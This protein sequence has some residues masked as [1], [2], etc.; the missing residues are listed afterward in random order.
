MRYLP[1]FLDVRQRPV[2]LVGG[3]PVALRKF[4][5]L[6]SAGA[7]TTVVAPTLSAEFA[8][9]MAD[10][11]SRHIAALFAPEQLR[12]QHLVIA[13]TNHPAVNRSVAEAA[14]R[15]G[16]WAN[17][18]DDAENSSCIVPA[19]VDRSPLIVAISSGGSAP[20][21]A[22]WVRAKIEVLLD[23]SLGSLALLCARWRSRIATQIA[24]AQRRDFYTT[25][26]TGEVADLVRC[27]READADAAVERAL[28][29]ARAPGS[30]AGRVI[31][32]GA[33]PGDP[34]L[35]TLHALRALQSADVIL[36]DRLVSSDVLALA[37]RDAA[38]V[39][40]G[41]E[42][43]GVS[44]AQSTTEALMIEHARAGRVVVRLKGGDPFVFG[45]GGEELEALRRAGIAYEVVPGIS[46]AA[47]AAAYAGIPLTHRD[48]AAGLRFLTA[49]RRDGTPEP[50][51]ADWA[52]S[53]ETLAIYMGLGQLPTL[54]RELLRHGRDPQ[55][56]VALIENVSRPH[57]R[58]AVGAL[59]Q[60]EQ[61]ALVHGF[62]SPTLII[63]G[64]AAA[65]ASQ[66]HWFG[67]TPLAAA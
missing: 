5:L 25:L 43:G 59:A 57:Q 33:G 18:V 65:F 23:A 64:D 67:A 10:G 27:G 17:I 66:L 7:R 24:A 48:C 11:S 50:D 8:P 51:W 60:A 55:T 9:L 63:I 62:E 2:L 29:N 39:D 54:R 36:H 22:R 58:I 41:K 20:M 21:L 42:G 31:L 56:P 16:M 44:V 35:L 26:L 61:L 38:R 53:R 19:I 13:A 32:V 14:L 40:V 6:R 46:A 1:L 4:V 52:R 12:G 34:G 15:L 49:H 45:R 30:V 37:R 28:A 47:A 3:G